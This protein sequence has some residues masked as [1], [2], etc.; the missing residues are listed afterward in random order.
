[1]SDPAPHG[2][3]LV[4][5]GPSAVGKSTLIARL[6]TVPGRRLSVSATTRA[7]RP[8]EVDGVHYRFTDPAGFQRL[9][10][11]G[12]LLEWAE[13]HGRRYGTPTSEVD[14]H[15]RLGTT[16]L[17]DLDSQGFRAV[18][19]LRPGIVG[20]FVAPPNFEE[21][22]RRIRRRSTEDE[23]TIQKRLSHARREMDAS[24]EYHHVVVNDALDRA[25][26][27]IEAVLERLRTG[28]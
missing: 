16:V 19:A 22:E 2:S 24:A 1:L 14:P 5:S 26:A 8:G 21:L 3:A 10:E 4:I 7:P 9:V 27:E 6:L 18:R 25:A 20:V 28:R 12:G 11:S 13:V 23:A 15:L 17:L